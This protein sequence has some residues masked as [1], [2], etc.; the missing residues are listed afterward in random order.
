MNSDTTSLDR[1]HDIVL[2]PEVSRWPPA[3]GVW[4]ILAL[5]LGF[6]F[7]LAYRAWKHRRANAYR[8][9]ALRELAEASSPAMIAEL[10][11]RTALAV[12]PRETVAGR[13]GTE[14]VDWLAAQSPESVPAGV[15][16]QL[17]AG[18]YGNPASPTDCRALAEFAGG[19]IRHH[20]SPDPK[21]RR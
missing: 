2:P 8:R 3:P 15:R 17:T 21:H 18:I 7:I 20:R 4:F 1:L 9:A 16:E 13:T 14:W 6:V 10:L 5:L 19:W 12:F 11:R